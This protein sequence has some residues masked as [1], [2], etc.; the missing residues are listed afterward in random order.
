MCVIVLIFI[1]FAYSFVYSFLH[2]YIGI[3]KE[4]LVP[5]WRVG[6]IVV[7]DSENTMSEIRKG[8]KSLTQLII[9]ANSLVQLA[10]P[11]ILSPIKGSKED[12][13]IQKFKFKYINILQSNIQLCHQ[14]ITQSKSPYLSI[15]SLPKGALYIMIKIHFEAMIEN[16]FSSDTDFSEKLLQSENLVVLPGQCFG[17]SGYIRLVICP[18]YEILQMALTRLIDFCYR[19]RR[20]NDTTITD[21]GAAVESNL[22]NYDSI[23]SSSS[24]SISNSRGDTNDTVDNNNSNNKRL[25]I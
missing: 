16:V 3:A 12:I 13:S 20:M 6:W 9:G 7:H 14:M 8:L 15:T 19:H 4:F 25:K 24:S 21:A 10:I 1:K 17:M 11:S 2:M 18:P 22:I 23:L 5:G